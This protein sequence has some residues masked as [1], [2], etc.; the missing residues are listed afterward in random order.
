VSEA[1]LSVTS[2]RPYGP[3]REI[4]RSEAELLARNQRDRRLV[5]TI[6]S[7]GGVWTAYAGPRLVN[8]YLY[9]KA[10]RPLPAQLRVPAVTLENGQPVVADED[11]W[12]AEC[13]CPLCDPEAAVE[14]LD[15]SYT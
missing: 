10:A 2:L 13:G 8:A 6:T 12:S 4:E 1:G 3:F 14:A 9:F 11:G 7:T 5:L 15:S